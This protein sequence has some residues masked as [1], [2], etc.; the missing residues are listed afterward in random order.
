MSNAPVVI[1]EGDV[2]AFDGSL[3]CD[4]CCKFLQKTFVN[5]TVLCSI[6]FAAFKCFEVKK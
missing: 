4:D 5:I 6:T 1:E 2:D 3:F